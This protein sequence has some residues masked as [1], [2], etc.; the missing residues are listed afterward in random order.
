MSDLL[1]QENAENHVVVKNKPWSPQAENVTQNSSNTPVWK[2]WSAWISWIWGRACYSLCVLSG[3]CWRVSVRDPLT[4][5]DGDSMEVMFLSKH[6]H[7]WQIF[8][9]QS[10]PG[11]ICPIGMSSSTKFWWPNWFWT[12][13]V[14]LA[15]TLVFK[16]GISSFQCTLHSW[17][18][19]WLL[20]FAVVHEL[21]NYIQE[22]IKRQK[23]QKKSTWHI[24][25][26]S[27]ARME[28]ERF[29]FMVCSKK[30]VLG[31]LT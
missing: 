2:R 7:H 4:M 9:M 15:C 6:H 27:R 21:I 3:A 5:G 19:F 10:T 31:P 24:S 17:L 26:M 14:K 29:S 23:G 11:D 20:S 25:K 12:G 30:Q 16:R 28:I 22:K 8:P 18:A 1:S 13:K